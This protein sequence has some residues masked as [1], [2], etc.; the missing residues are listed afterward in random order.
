MRHS[1]MAL[2]LGGLLLMAVSAQAQKAPSEKVAGPSFKAMDADK[3]G[4]LTLEEVMSYA[5]KKS[6][7]TEPFRITD[8]DLDGDGVLTP[9]EQR[10][11]GINGMEQ[12][13]AVNLKEMDING[14]GYI[15]REDLDE[16]YRRK[17]REAFAKADADKNKALRPS[18]FALF[19]F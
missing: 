11:A 8:A 19:R 2:L 6:S 18:E 10:K 17:H 7:D 13:G 5:K 3:S 12:F 16:Y 4:H 14:D 9:E 1:T 15:S